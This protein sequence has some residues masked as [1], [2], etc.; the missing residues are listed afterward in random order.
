MTDAHNQLESVM[1]QHADL[2]YFGIG[3][4]DEC[5][6]P[7]EQRRI[8]HAAQRE[9]LRQS[10]DRVH[11]TVEWLRSNIEPVQAINQRR[12]SYGLKHVAEKQIGYITNG[13][14]IAAALIVGYRHEARPGSPNVSF[15]MGERSIKAV[16]RA[17]ETARHAARGCHPRAGGFGQV[18]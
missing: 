16:E 2:T 1:R 17:N 4:F 9:K 13:V 5:R 10:A 7:P 3:I 12:T 6:K 11:A 8:E 18:T 14:F 15:G